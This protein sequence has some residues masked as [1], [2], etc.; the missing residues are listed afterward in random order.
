M[1]QQKWI[2]GNWKMNGS[3]ASNQQ[4]LLALQKP[5][6]AASA[7]VYCAVAVPDVYL[8]SAKE[9][10]RGFPL[11]IGAQDVSRFGD[12]G[13]YTGEI[14]AQMLA[15]VGAGFALIG[16]SE[17]RQ[18]FQEDNAILLSKLQHC[19]SAHI[20]PILCVGETLAQR[21]SAQE[22]A[23]VGDQLA[24]LAELSATE[25][26]VAYEP[27][28]A[29][30]TGKIPTT[31]QIAEMHQFIYHQILSL[32]GKDVKIRVLYGGSVNTKNA[33][34]ILAVPHVDGALVG[35]ASLQADS[36]TAIIQAACAPAL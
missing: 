11:V 15:D 25:V 1:W 13:A 20:L 2:M 5:V 8:T 36:F 27:V 35:G 22:K 9:Q 29:I 16:H 18:Y 3:L 6:S 19:L 34:E 10:V 21:E 28:W 14:N 26:V 31:R 30:G 7:Q 23:V 17:R 33:A 4:L 24:I 12:F 32:C